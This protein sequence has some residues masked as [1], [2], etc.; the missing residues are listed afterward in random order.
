MWGEDVRFRGGGEG[1]GID[2]HP[3]RKVQGRVGKEFG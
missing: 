2:D 1:D 3:D